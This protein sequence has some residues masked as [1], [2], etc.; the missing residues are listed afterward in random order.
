MLPIDLLLIYQNL[1][2]VQPLQD[3]VGCDL[4]PNNF[5]QELQVD[6]RKKRT[7]DYSGG[8]K[9]LAVSVLVLLTKLTTSLKTYGYNTS[10]VSRHRHSPSSKRKC[11]NASRSTK[12]VTS[13]TTTKSFI[14]CIMQSTFEHILARS[15]FLEVAWTFSPSRAL[16][17]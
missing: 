9:V 4:P 15:L 1:I 5:S 12:V 6:P 10:W 14:R 17:P 3:G 7:L 16:I 13:S 8:S 2:H 11:S